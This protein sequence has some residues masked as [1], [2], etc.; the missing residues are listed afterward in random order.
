MEL[1][2]LVKKQKTLDNSWIKHFCSGL[3]TDEIERKLEQI[4][5]A[6]QTDAFF[7]Q[8]RDANED[9]L[10][11]VAEI[12]VVK[13]NLESMELQHSQ[14]VEKLKQDIAAKNSYI[15]QVCVTHGKAHAHAHIS[16]LILY[17]TSDKNSCV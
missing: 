5:T 4:R 14:L 13:Q 10:S 2:N 6:P 3:S 9:V 15:E 17:L 1:Q 8:I 16:R 12:A 7:K 11:K